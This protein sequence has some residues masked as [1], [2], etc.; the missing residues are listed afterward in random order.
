ME[1]NSRGLFEGTN[2]AVADIRLTSL[3]IDSVRAKFEP[4]TSKYTTQ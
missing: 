4:G 3:G 2:P 1:E